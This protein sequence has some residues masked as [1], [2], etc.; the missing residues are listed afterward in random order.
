VKRCD[1]STLPAV[2]LARIILSRTI[3]SFVI[4]LLLIASASAQSLSPTLLFTF[5]CNK[6]F[7]CPDGFF[8]VSLIESPDGNFYGTAVGG[9][10]GLNAQGTVFKMTPS[11]KVSVIYSFFEQPSGLLP[12]GSAPNGLVEGTDG[13]LYGV[14]TFN[15]PLGLGLAFKLSKSGT[16]VDLHD[17]CAGF[18]CNDG[19]YPAF[20]TQALDGNF[21]GTTG[22]S[23]YPADV[24]FRLSPTGAFKVMHTFGA[25]KAPKDGDGAF[26][27]LQAPDGTFYSATVAG[28]QN[29]PFNTVFRFAPKSDAYKILHGFDFSDYA[30]SNLAQAPTGE[31]FGLQVNSQLY[32]ISTAGDYQSLGPLS[33]TQYL[34]GEILM[35]SDG[36]LWGNFQGGDCG[37]Q[38]MVFAATTA[39]KVL[40]NILFD[41]NTIGQQLGSMIQA[42]NGKFYGVTLG[43]GGVSQTGLTN[44]TIWVLDAGLPPPSPALVNFAPATGAAG[45]TVLLQGQH[46]VGTTAVSFNGVPAAFKVLTVNYISVTVPTGAKT[47]KITI[48]NAG[49][50]TTSAK[51]FKIP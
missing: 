16:I 36:N 2:I 27:L 13:F 35:A 19:A 24:L 23:G 17:F 26:G 28:A 1:P 32:E 37:D 12:Y 14:T 50:T 5:P 43:N 44:G 46:F 39:G 45:T 20:V 51:S 49:G 8:P 31:L 9:G 4:A 18:E 42:A 29:S 11:G 10:T 25:P 33:S 15:G 48:T 6:K 22:P 7:V 47:G 3:Q 34:D 41:C 30:A 21:Y 38:G 40:Q